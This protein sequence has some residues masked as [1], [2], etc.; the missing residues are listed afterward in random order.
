MNV[1]AKKNT[2]CPVNLCESPKN[3]NERARDIFIFTDSGSYN[4]VE[5]IIVTRWLAERTNVA[6]VHRRT[7]RQMTDRKKNSDEGMVRLLHYL[8]IIRNW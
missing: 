6:A 2:V 7:H 5:G 4:S 8:S 3:T 1:E